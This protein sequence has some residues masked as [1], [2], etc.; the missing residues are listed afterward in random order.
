ATHTASPTEPS[1]DDDCKAA[2]RATLEYSVALGEMA[3][4]LELDDPMVAVGAADAMSAA[5]ANLR[6]ALPSAPAEA[7]DFL[8]AIEG[9]ATLVKQGIADGKASPAIIAEL[10]ALFGDPSYDAGSAALEAYFKQSCAD[11]M[12]EGDVSTQ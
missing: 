6:E 7:V 11:A 5:V 2:L 3:R 12:A 4:A 8:T 10:A 9:S 1:G